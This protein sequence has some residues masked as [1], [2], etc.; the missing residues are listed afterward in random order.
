MSYLRVVLG[1]ILGAG[2]VQADELVA[3]HVAARRNVGRDPDVPLVAVGDQVVRRPLA[4][5]AV[6]INETRLLDLEEVE[7]PS[8]GRCAA[9][10]AL[11]EVVDH[12]AVM[13]LGPGVP[14]HGDGRARGDR[15][16]GGAGRGGL[17]AGNVIR[18]ESIGGNEAV[19]LVEREPASLLRLGARVVP[20]LPASS[21]ARPPS[22]ARRLTYRAVDFV[23]GLPVGCDRLDVAVS[24]DQRSSKDR[25]ADEGSERLHFEKKRTVEAGSG[26]C[27]YRSDRR[28]RW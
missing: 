17:V 27:W 11:G 15:D 23:V 24:A 2:A 10:G 13:R 21:V 26:V 28:V 9:A 12:G 25:E 4:G 5:R 3:K 20:H 8:A 14:A 7:A 6:A 1:T 18:T 22:E 16:L 19:V